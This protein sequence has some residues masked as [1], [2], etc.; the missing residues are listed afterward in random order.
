MASKPAARCTVKE[1]GAYVNNVKVT[2]EYAVA[3]ADE[4]CADAGW[5]CAGARRTGGDRGLGA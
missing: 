3:M 2:A 5:C 4:L 1:G